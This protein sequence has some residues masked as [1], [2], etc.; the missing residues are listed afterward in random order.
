MPYSDAK[1][2]MQVHHIIV[3]PNYIVFTQFNITRTHSIEMSTSID[4]YNETATLK[5]TK[6]TEEAWVVSL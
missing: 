3:G 1:F 2:A 4:T 5:L 6:G